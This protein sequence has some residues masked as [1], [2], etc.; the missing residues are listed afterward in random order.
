[1]LC[2]HLQLDL[3][4]CDVLLASIAVR[5]LLRL[6]KLG[7]DGLGTEILQGIPLDRVDAQN[8]VGLDGSES[9]GH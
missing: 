6:R 8:G 4:L 9:A 3:G 5:D 7:L 2:S 1:M